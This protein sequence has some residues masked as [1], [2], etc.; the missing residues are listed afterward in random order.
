MGEKPVKP[1]DVARNK[2]R[3]KF[4][5]KKGQERRKLWLPWSIV[6]IAVVAAGVIGTMQLLPDSGAQVSRSST[7]PGLSEPIETSD[8]APVNVVA[9]TQGH[10]AYP[11]VV[12]EAGS[13]IRFALSDFSDGTAR[14]YT[15]MY[16][17]QPIEI[18]L[19]ES[20]D[21]VVRAAFNACDVCYGAK[22][23]Y[24]QSGDAMVCENCG[25]Q[26]AANRINVEQ[27]GCNPAPLERRIEGEYLV[28]DVD[29]IVR[30]YRFF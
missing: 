1:V 2:K 5:V 8:A 28:I 14:Y 25:R 17:G 23:G 12:E 15:Y 18:F 19:L 7:P 27:G 29:N 13:V 10:A 21:G 22:R 24:T 4:E 3:T 16:E 26:F 11:M 30:G 6:V 20:Q 9:A